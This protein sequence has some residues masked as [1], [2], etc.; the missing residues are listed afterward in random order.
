[1]S[2]FNKYC[3]IGDSN[4]NEC[5]NPEYNRVYYNK[6]SQVSKLNNYPEPPSMTPGPINSNKLVNPGDSLQNNIPSPVSDNLKNNSYP[7]SKNNAPS[8]TVPFNNT[9]LNYASAGHQNGNNTTFTN[10]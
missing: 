2:D 6:D 8:N 7:F 9:T 5:A 3:Y 10:K 1:M 4:T